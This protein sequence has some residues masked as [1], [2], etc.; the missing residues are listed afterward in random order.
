ME[1]NI[2]FEN[3]WMGAKFVAEGDLSVDVVRRRLYLK[4]LKDS[5]W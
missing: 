3:G 4:L 1:N 2:P 5:K